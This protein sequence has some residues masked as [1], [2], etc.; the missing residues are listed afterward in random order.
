MFES[1]IRQFWIEAND[2]DP[3]LKVNSMRGVDVANAQI[4]KVDP[5]VRIQD[6]KDARPVVS[7]KVTFVGF[8]LDKYTQKFGFLLILSW[9][10]QRHKNMG[11]NNL[12][13][14]P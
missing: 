1:G 11:I 3:L 9:P 6:V 10:E 14:A 12:R 5:R 7:K 13:T 2:A 4:P 8:L